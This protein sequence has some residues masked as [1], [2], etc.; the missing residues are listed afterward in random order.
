MRKLA[1]SYFPLVNAN[2]IC[3]NSVLQVARVTSCNGEKKLALLPISPNS[4]IS[5]L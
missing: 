5:C 2:L 3:S 4:M 1:C